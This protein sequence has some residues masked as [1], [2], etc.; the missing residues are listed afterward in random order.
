M[1]HKV[2]SRGIYVAVFAGLLGLTALTVA[3]SFV[4]LGSLHLPAALT[5]ATLKALLVVLF[6]MHVWGGE[7]LV[8][9]V[10]A[11]AVLW[12]GILLGLTCSDYLTRAWLAPA[13]PLPRAS[14]LPA[15]R[16]E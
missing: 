8:W 1:A 14:T 13:E 16:P 12:L 11:G 4:E 2:V 15:G 5:I 9:Q 10:L 3:T 6:F 7:R